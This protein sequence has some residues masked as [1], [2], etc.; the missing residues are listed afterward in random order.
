[1]WHVTAK[2]KKRHKLH[3]SLAQAA[4]EVR[5]S[6]IYAGVQQVKGQIENGSFRITKREATPAEPFNLERLFVQNFIILQSMLI[7]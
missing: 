6:V 7:E 1:M 2:F 3:A 5:Q 4:R